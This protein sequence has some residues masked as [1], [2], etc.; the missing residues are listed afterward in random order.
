VRARL[1][2]FLTVAALALPTAAAA[3]EPDAHVAVVPA[4]GGPSAVL[5]ATSLDQPGV[6]ALGWAPEGDAVLALTQ[7]IDGR[8]SVVVRHPVDG[9]AAVTTGVLP[10]PALT[11]AFSRDGRLAAAPLGTRDVVL[12]GA[13]PPARV[14]GR[15]REWPIALAWS[16]DGRRLA[17]AAERARGAGTTIALVDGATG[18]VLRRFRVA[19]RAEAL[20]WAPDGRR[21][22]YAG[23]EVV[24]RVVV[25][26]TRTGARR[27]AARPGAEQLRGSPAFSPAGRLALLDYSRVLF[28]DPP[29]RLGLEGFARAAGCPFVVHGL[30][31]SPDGRS[32]ALALLGGDLRPA[33]GVVDVSDTDASARILAR[34]V[35]QAIEHIA[36]S[37]DG[38]QIAYAATWP[39]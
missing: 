26:D 6:A 23:G 19:G 25:L 2:A 13:G 7:Q 28:A 33:L 4:A 38:T 35:S 39:G 21:L 29:G 8:R 14:R 1:T 9:G 16:A 17:I 20:G 27:T 31:W 24:A 10:A 11:A 32:L 22:A 37:P 5:A 36:W 34:P 30:A 3:Q 12:R 18:R 15:R